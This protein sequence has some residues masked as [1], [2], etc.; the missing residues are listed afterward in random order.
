MK[1]DRLFRRVDQIAALK[2]NYNFGL[3]MRRGET[4]EA[5]LERYVSEGG[6]ADD[7]ALIYPEPCESIEEWQAM[8][9]E[10]LCRPASTG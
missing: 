9:N 2:Q 1:F 4:P 7:I 5:A 6:N 10:W 3:E 8:V